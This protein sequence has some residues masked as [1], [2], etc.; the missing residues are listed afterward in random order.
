MTIES[1]SNKVLAFFAR[2]PN[3]AFKSKEL[4]RR[5]SIRTNEEHE[6]LKQAL[7]HL[8]DTNQVKRIKG[9]KF[10][11]LEIPQTVIGTLQMTKQGLGFVTVEGMDEDVFIAPRFRNMA[12]HGDKV[13]VSLFAQRADKP[14]EGEKREGEIIRVIERGR[15]DVVGTL[16]RS[17]NLFTVVPDD[18]RIARD[19]FVADEYLNKAK[20]GDKVVVQIDSWG[21][22][23]L[24]PEG[25]IVEVLGKAGEVSAEIRSVVRE[26]K[27]PLSFPPVVLK[28]V[29]TLSTVIPE[30]EVRRRL[31]FRDHVCFTIDPE[32]AKDFDD[33]VSLEAL[34]DGD[35]RLGVHIAD[36]S[37]YIKEATELDKEAL[38]RATSVYFPNMVIP[39][40]PEKLSN[41]AC[42]L[43]PNEDRLAFS[44]FMTVTP[45][46]L[47][48]EYD[49]RE[50]VICSKRRFTYEEV[51]EILA[52]GT[53]AQGPKD[54]KQII[55]TLHAMQELSATLTKKRMKEGSIDF[56][57]PEA[58]FRFDDEGKPSEIIK[59]TRLKSHRLV[60][61]F[62]L[63]ANQVVAKHIGLAKKEEHRKPFL[64]RIH[65][66]PDPDR[67]RELAA[68]VEK[69]G[70]RINLDSGV[71]S[72]ELQ[73]LLDQVRGT[74]EEN[75]INEVALR[76]MAKAIYSE[77]NIGHYGLGFDYYSHFTSPI[78]RYPDLVVHRLLKEYNTSLSL[79]RREA[80]G[81]RLPFIAKQSSA[82][83]RVAM[84]AE[85]AA[86]KVMQ[87]EYMKRHLG[88][89]FQGIVSGVMRFGLFIEIND[90][91]VEGMIHVRDLE[92]DF[93]TYDEKQYALI[94]RRTGNQYRLGDSVHV[95][96][97]RVN[98][99]EREI[100][101][102]MV[103]EI[104]HRAK[105]AKRRK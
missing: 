38:K 14:R 8:T 16:R 60:E 102:V 15:V 57:T 26:F 81:Q 56:E 88:D 21:V 36:V 10:G 37:Y 1:V 72:K 105:K 39:M 75:V 28:E 79:Q 97:V 27:L 50:S 85:R 90:L 49:I 51:E 65:D 71:S 2:Y 4:A 48:K 13:E 83:E 52:G 84:E 3:Q 58:K 33:A 25:R 42:S 12:V 23:H 20:E 44:V 34:K 45:K 66:S 62:M 22:G 6:V 53:P 77:N 40:L 80:I 101:F 35:V 9:G 43:R 95:K 64:Y 59:K 93:Y 89:E 7:R 30:E 76:S 69:F 41:I 54:S 87:V 67:I 31:D 18:G 91:L 17:R 82:M 46:G 19:V 55:E 103:G 94:G 61:E 47:V 78:R 32:D 29:D 104:S 11:H 73:K 86:I 98:P 63:L 99:E 96:V 92:D 5:L 68:F 74:E 24:N 100:D 70:Y